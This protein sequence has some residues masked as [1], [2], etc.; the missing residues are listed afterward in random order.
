MTSINSNFIYQEKQSLRLILAIIFIIIITLFVWQG[1]I[2]YDKISFSVV[3]FFVLY[4][5]LV[6]NFYKLEIKVSQNDISA[7]FGIGVIIKSIKTEK[8][9]IDTIEKV[10][11]PWY[12]GIGIRYT[13]KGILYNY[14]P[15]T[16]LFFKSKNRE[17]YFFVSTNNFQSLK[18]AIIHSSK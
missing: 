9:D 17:Q 1:E 2:G 6:L 11:V 18:D 15:G 7:K 16:S 3:L 8:I 10:V 4:V 14:R 5:I 13:K 12:Y